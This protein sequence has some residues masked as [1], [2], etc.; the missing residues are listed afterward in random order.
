MDDRAITF[1]SW[2][3]LAKILT[4]ERTRLLKHVHAHP[5]PSIASFAR[6]L[7]RQYKRVHEDV[8]AL[9]A[10]G[11]LARRSGQVRATADRLRAEI[12]L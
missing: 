4:G 6:S 1:E 12:V 5:E 3:G 7:G 10:A 2:E 8:T 11:L 9:E